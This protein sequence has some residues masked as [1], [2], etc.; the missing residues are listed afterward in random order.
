MDNVD[1]AEAENYWNNFTLK[2]K[3]PDASNVKKRIERSFEANKM[4]RENPIEISTMCLNLHLML[5]KSMY[6]YEN[7]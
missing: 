7:Q 1:I 6:N 3:K 2:P 5:I 4:F